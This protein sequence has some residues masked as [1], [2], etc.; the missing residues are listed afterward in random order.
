[1]P[2]PISTRQLKALHALQETHPDLGVLSIYIAQ[3][4]DASAINNPEL[5]RLIL[6]K[7][8]RRIVAGEADAQDALIQHLENFAI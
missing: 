5:A 4:F 2:L 8:C 7:M 1:M 3:A 6:Q